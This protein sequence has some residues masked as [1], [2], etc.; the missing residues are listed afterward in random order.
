MFKFD[1]K[2]YLK[3]IQT[4][5]NKYLP[6]ILTGVGVAGMIGTT[7]FAVAKTPKAMMLVE[8]KKLDENKDELT[9]LEVV[10]ATW[11][12]YVPVVAMGA[13]STACVVAGCVTGTRRFMALSAAYALS[14]NNYKE[15][16]D[17]VIKALGG[18]T[19]E[20]IQDNIIKDDMA[21]HPVNPNNI[22]ET[23][24]GNYLC[25]DKTSGSYFHSSIEHVKASVN[26]VNR[27][28]IMDSRINLNDLYEELH[29]PTTELGDIMGWNITRG[30][31]EPKF[32]YT[33][34]DDGTPCLAI[35]FMNGLTYDYENVFN[36]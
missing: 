10:E 35:S 15:Y 22:I 27:R 9:K 31:I 5:A 14:E 12:C 26:E 32:T 19:E 17:H 36:G 23:G 24:D 4:T 6:Q 33:S 29:L 34:D 2:P 3:T 7:I 20:D 13:A 11:K 25:F 28:L 18:E 16:K 8:E 21:K 30:L 1:I